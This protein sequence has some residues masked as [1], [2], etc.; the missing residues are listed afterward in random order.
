M[1]LT[2]GPSLQVWVALYLTWAYCAVF[3]SEKD[4]FL[5]VFYLFIYMQ[6]HVRGLETDENDFFSRSH[7]Y[8]TGRLFTRAAHLQICPSILVGTVYGR[9]HPNDPW[10]SGATQWLGHL[11]AQGRRQSLRWSSAPSSS[12]CR[13][14]GDKAR[15]LGNV[16]LL[17]IWQS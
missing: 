13:A 17:L 4:G 10:C 9:P 8:Q 6:P 11:S 1:L 3:L 15:T 5:K 7:Y 2:A 12:L 16:W 14:E